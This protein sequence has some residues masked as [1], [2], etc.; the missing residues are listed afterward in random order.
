M[1][2]PDGPMI[3]VN[4]PALRST[5][6]SSR[7]WTAASPV[8]VLLADADGAGRG[9]GGDGGAGGAC[10]VLVIWCLLVRGHG[11]A[12]GCRCARPG[13]RAAADRRPAPMGRC[14]PA[15]GRQPTSTGRADVRPAPPRG[16]GRTLRA[17]PAAGADCWHAARGCGSASRS[18][19]TCVGPAARPRRPRRLR[20][21][22]RTSSSCS[23]AAPSSGG[24]TRP[25]SP[26]RCSP[27]P[28]VALGFEPVQRRLERRPAGSCDGG[29]PSP[30][31]VLS[32]FSET[33]TGGYTTEELPGPD[34]QAAGRG[35]RGR[36]GPGVAHRPG[37]ADPGRHLA[38]GRR[39]G[40]T[41]AAGAGR[42]GAGRH[43]RRPAGA[44]GA[45]R[46][47]GARRASGC[48][49]ARTSR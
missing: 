27:R 13:P 32:R 38:A 25:T 9:A 22:R 47:A 29:T 48:R 1:P 4:W 31:D 45:P 7:A 28:I 23:A 6:T 33:V 21:R 41:D 36:V 34:G 16:F 37:P 44:P 30:Y 24:P 15:R 10:V 11:L 26:S 43:R 17:G 49:S 40:P 12:G 2:E 5:D 19:G 3:A 20:R 39:G 18:R 8:A 14:A 42:R 46:R 35:H